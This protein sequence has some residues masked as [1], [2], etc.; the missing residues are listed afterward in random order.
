MR[1]KKLDLNLLVALDALLSERSITRAARHV[2]LSQSAMS[3]ALSRLRDYFG[4]ELLVPVGRQLELTPRAQM[5]HEAVR[6]LLVRADNVLKAEP[7]LDPAH[8]TRR[9]SLLLSDY[10]NAVLMP[11]VIA[12]ARQEAPQVCFDLLSQRPDHPPHIALERGEADLLL[13]VEGLTSP[14]HP[15]ERVQDDAFVCLAPADHPTV[16]G[17]ITL[18]QYT[19]LGHVVMQPTPGLRAL[20]GIK[21]EELGI[22]RNEEVRSF[23]FLSLPMLLAPDR[24]ATVQRRVAALIGAQQP[25]SNLQCLALPVPLPP[26][27]SVMQWHKHRASDQGI[28]WLRDI[29]KRAAAR[30]GP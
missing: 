30:L 25:G 26:I 1:F 12:L 6:D 18:E 15:C 28:H 20:D 4:D 8:Y 5:L 19:Q 16:Q 2:H 22:K 29:V 9:F 11:Q 24:I 17:A 3:A 7:E 23:S 27:H 21:L 14:E 10:T 13:I